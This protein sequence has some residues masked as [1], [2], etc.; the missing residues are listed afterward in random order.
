MRK[1]LKFLESV[2]MF[3]AIREIVGKCLKMLEFL[4]EMLKFLVNM[5]KFLVKRL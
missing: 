3:V 5:L 2:E 1:K 4:E